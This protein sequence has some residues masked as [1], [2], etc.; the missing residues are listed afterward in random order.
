MGEDGGV[1]PTPLSLPPLEDVR[2]EPV[3]APLA[4]DR[5]VRWGILAPGRIASAFAANLTETDQAELAAVGSR[6][7][8]S[9]RAFADRHHA[10]RA[11][12][13]YR[14]LVEDPDVDVVYVASPHGLHHEHVL[15]ALEAGKPV[16]CEKAFALNSTQAGELVDVARDNGLFLME[17]MWTACLP[18]VRRL[19]QLVFSGEVGTVRQV[20]ADLGFLVDRPAT[21]RMFDPALGGG[22]LLDMGIYPLTLAHL[23]LGAPDR[24]AALGTLSELGVDLDVAVT[25]AYAGGAVAALTAS[26]TSQSPRTATISTDR[27]LLDFPPGFH[28]PSQVTW[29]NG[30]GEVTTFA[31]PLLGTGLAHE[32]L[33]VVRCLRAGEIESP[34]VPHAQTLSLMAQ[35]DEIRGQLGARYAADEQEPTT[36]G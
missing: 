15:L 21:D 9:A 28:H 3:S 1:S 11:Y 27:G 30:E 8:E 13:D 26:M 7:L 14:A 24:V 23:F 33:E 31:E 20:R 32:V 25:Q 19:R 22:V 17:A 4:V 34:L 36:A 12:G 16:L 10:A 2:G 35:L 18:L 6:S 29:T 5:P